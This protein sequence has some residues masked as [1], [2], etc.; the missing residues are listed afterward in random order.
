MEDFLS[1]ES[2]YLSRDLDTA[3]PNSVLFY[4]ESELTGRLLNQVYSMAKEKENL[5]CSFHDASLIKQPMDF[6]EQI[7]QLKYG[8]KYENLKEKDWFKKITEKEDLDIS[9]FHIL[10]GLCARERKSDNPNYRKLPVIFIDGIEE[11][12]F[13]MDYGHFNKKELE[14]IFTQWDKGFGTALRSG[15]HQTLDGVFYGSVRKTDGIEYAETL[16][17][18]H[19]L[20]YAGNFRP[21]MVP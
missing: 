21:M 9:D 15:L 20:F 5:L 13:N 14:Q 12:F 4:G 3:N 17:R 16:G 7:L 10:A 1:R 2:E 18:Y 11:L 19:Y 6:F 8:D